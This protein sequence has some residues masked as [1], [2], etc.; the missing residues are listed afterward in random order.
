[1]DWVVLLAGGSGT[2]FWPLSTPR[3]PKQLLP[4][5]GDTPTAVAAV[6]TIAP[7]VPRERVLVV[8]GEALAGPLGDVL[9]LPAGNFLV[10]PRAASTA[11]ALVWA[12]HE[13]RRRDPEATLLAMHADWHLPDPD[14]FRRVAAS[15]LAAARTQDRLIT[16]GVTPAR[17]ETGYG[18]VVPG[19]PA[20]PGVSLV[21]RFTEKP[22]ARTAA[23]LIAG[24]ALW[25]SGLFAWTAAR[26]LEEIRMHT[27]EVATALHHLD[28]GDVSAYFAAVTPVSIDVGLLERSD[29]VAVVEGAFPWDDI[30]TWE[31]LARIR[32][33]DAAGNVVFGPGHL[34]D[35]RDC[36]V[37]S[38]GTPVVVSGV[39]HLIVIAAG[40]RVLVLDRARAAELKAT[41]EAV[42]PD[43]RDLP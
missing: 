6:D 4:L 24:G 28:A 31:A 8:T 27:P 22:D 5:A 16:A 15:A 33:T 32:P 17:V 18:Y 40:G 2:R 7:L 25:N 43:V 41:L 38:D 37:W 13:A 14:A 21:A 9:D 39:H 42:P 11:P 23:Q 1:M 36:I 26:L 35:S 30:G 12:A 34:V 10:E 29:R 19:D 3:R 20:G